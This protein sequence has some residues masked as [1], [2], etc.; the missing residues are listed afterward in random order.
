MGGNIISA[1]QDISL[2][3]G[4]MLVLNQFDCVKSCV[5]SSTGDGNMQAV[6]MCYPARRDRVARRDGGSSGVRCMHPEYKT[7]DSGASASVQVLSAMGKIERTI[8]GY[9]RSADILRNEPKKGSES[10]M[11]Q[12]NQVWGNHIKR[13]SNMIGG[14]VGKGKRCR[15]IMQI[16]AFNHLL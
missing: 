16:K 7:E 9:K 12:P 3:T 8:T 14:E 10:C 13:S 5:M 2:A 11:T 6:L 15:G 4:Q 1:Y